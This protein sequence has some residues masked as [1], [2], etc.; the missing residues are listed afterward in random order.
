MAVGVIG[1]TAEALHWQRRRQCS[2]GSPLSVM[3]LPTGTEKGTYTNDISLNLSSTS[4]NAGRTP[5]K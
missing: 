1:G 5:E 2:R 4:R 3:L